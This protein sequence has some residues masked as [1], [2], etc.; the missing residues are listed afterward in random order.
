MS[1]GSL[2]RQHR[3]EHRKHGD[4]RHQ[5][6]RV[7]RGGVFEPVQE[8]RLI[9]RDPQKAENGQVNQVANVSNPAGRPTAA[10]TA[11]RTS[12]CAQHPKRD[13]GTGGNHRQ[14]QTSGDSQTGKQELHHHEREVDAGRT[15]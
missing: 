14:D 1:G 12:G 7:D 3:A 13:Q 11:R 2:R 15:G 8:E 4:G 6:G 5:N 9:G 10:L